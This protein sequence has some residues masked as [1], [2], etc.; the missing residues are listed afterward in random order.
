MKVELPSALMKI[1][2]SRKRRGDPSQYIPINKVSYI[3]HLLYITVFCQLHQSYLPHIDLQTTKRVMVRSLLRNQKDIDGPLFWWSNHSGNLVLLV[4]INSAPTY[5]CSSYRPLIIYKF[6]LA[7]Q[8][9]LYY[10][11]CSNI[12]T[13]KINQ[14]LIQ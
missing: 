4:K 2:H 1:W 11:I 7:R 14:N 13:E 8:I 5:S 12:N 10:E 6:N 3:I 9:T